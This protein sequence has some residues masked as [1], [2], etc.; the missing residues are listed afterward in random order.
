MNDPLAQPG[1]REALAR[2]ILDDID[3]H[4]QSAY[5]DGHRWH[6]GA[7]IIGDDC[8]RKLWYGFRWVHTPQHSGQALRLFNRGHLEEERFV[9]WLRGIGCEVSEFQEDGK[10]QHRISGVDGHFGGSLDGMLRLPAHYG[11]FPVFLSEFKTSNDKNFKKLVK[12]KVKK[13]KYQH[14]CQMSVYGG[15]YRFKYAVYIAINKNTDELYIEVVEL[16]WDLGEM[17]LRKA[18]DIVRTEH[19]PEKQSQDPTFWKCKFCD[20]QSV[21]HYGAELERNCRSCAFAKPVENGGWHCGKY[22]FVFSKDAH[23]EAL[24]NAGC[25]DWRPIA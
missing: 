9:A 10:T 21:C 11:G 25:A 1:A 6:L 15:T 8:A 13:S 2:Q 20:Y 22:N 14:F 23:D 24:V 19:P 18:E 12:D 16:D 5:N 7:S 3:A 17:L 4:C